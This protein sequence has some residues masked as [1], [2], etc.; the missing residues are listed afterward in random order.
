MAEVIIERVFRHHWDTRR[1]EEP[2]VLPGSGGVASANVIGADS[3]LRLL[4]VMVM[5]VTCL[6]SLGELFL[7]TVL[8]SNM[9]DRVVDRVRVG[10]GALRRVRWRESGMRGEGIWVRVL[11]LGRVLM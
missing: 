1:G 9:A 4:A 11:I 7:L 8:P 3:T 10:I 2:A 6:L 5:M